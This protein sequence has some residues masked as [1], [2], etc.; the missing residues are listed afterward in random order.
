M[1]E[2][3]ANGQVLRIPSGG[4][5]QVRCGFGELAETVV[6]HAEEGVRGSA[7]GELGEALFE[8]DGL[9]RGWRLSGLPLEKRARARLRRSPGMAGLEGEGFG[10]RAMNGFLVVILPRLEQ[11]EMRVGLG[12]GGVGF[13][14]G[15][16]GLFGFCELA[17]LLE[18]QGGLAELVGLGWR[19]CVGTEAVVRN[20]ANANLDCATGFTRFPSFG[21]DSMS[22][23]HVEA[24]THHCRSPLWMRQPRGG[25]DARL[26][27]AAEIGRTELRAAH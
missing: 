26:G 12:V 22:A 24:D 5:F 27:S 25:L 18:G 20:K 2:G 15:A 1:R 23:A 8:Q 14:E 9:T 10:D 19:L 6:T 4:G 7:S 11:A 21:F 3:E 17:P 13:A 16:P